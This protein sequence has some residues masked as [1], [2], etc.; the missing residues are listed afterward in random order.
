MK[1]TLLLLSAFVMLFV[2]HISAQEVWHV[3]TSDAQYIPVSQMAYFAHSDDSDLYVIVDNNGT[4][5]P[6][7]S[8]SFS[9]VP[10]A[11]EAI[12]SPALDIS[13]FP[14]PVFNTL[15]LGGLLQD[16]SVYVRSIEGATLIATTLSPDNSLLDVT[17]LPAGVYLLQVNNTT[18]K[19]IKK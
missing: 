14:N 8:I 4:A 2:T 6:T 9:Y 16:T 10:L 7:K 1:K 11:V 3:V 15:K 19:F 18:I 12:T 13:V 5:I 17:G